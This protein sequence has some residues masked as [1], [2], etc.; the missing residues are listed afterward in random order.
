LPNQ[1]LHP[2]DLT[3]EELVEIKQYF[4]EFFPKNL[5]AKRQTQL[6]GIEIAELQ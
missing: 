4:P 1:K 5:A 3:A 2:F 6:K